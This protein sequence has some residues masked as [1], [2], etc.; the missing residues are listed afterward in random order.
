MSVNTANVNNYLLYGGHSYITDSISYFSQKPA[1]LYTGLT[2]NGTHYLAITPTV[3]PRD[4]DVY[5]SSLTYVK[6]YDMPTGIYAYSI[7]FNG[8]HYLVTDTT[9]KRLYIY[10]DYTFSTYLTYKSL[11]YIAY[12]TFICWDGNNYYILSYTD[13]VITIIY[14]IIKIY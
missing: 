10:E 3:Y 9:N 13:H 12:P 4:V 5:S 14:R 6:K 8:T 11:S 2:F 1:G 7:L